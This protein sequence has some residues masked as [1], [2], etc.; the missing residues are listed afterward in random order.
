[1]VQNLAM[2]WVTNSHRLTSTKEM[3]SKLNWLSVNQLI[4]YHSFLLQYKVQKKS[5]PKHNLNQLNNS[6]NYRGRIDL[7]KRR[8]SRN[9]QDIYLTVDPNIRNEDRILVFKKRIKSWI[10]RNINIFS[11]NGD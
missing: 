7:T 9:I 2:C 6:I 11:D 3:L 1:M 5:L 4:Y 8:W 10:R